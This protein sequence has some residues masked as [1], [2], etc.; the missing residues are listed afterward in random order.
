MIL[1]ARNLRISEDETT[2]DPEY[3][4][5]F[6]EL[7]D[8]LNENS[9][10]ITLE[11]PNVSIENIMISYYEDEVV[12]TGESPDHIFRK[13]MSLSFIPEKNKTEIWG[14]NGVYQIRFN[15]K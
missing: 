5:P 15:K 13:E 11:L 3:I 2:I 6:Y 10:E 14:K 4:E 1:D 8:E 9:T 7:F 12:I